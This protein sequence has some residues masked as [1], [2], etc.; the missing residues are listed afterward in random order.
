MDIK[1]QLATL[2]R[3]AIREKIPEASDIEIS[4]ERPRDPSHGDLATNV[5]M[6]I[7]RK[8][9]RKPRDVAELLRGIADP[10]IESLEIAGPG[11]INIR[12]KAGAKTDVIPQVLAAGAAYGRNRADQPE[13]IQVEF[14]S[15]NPTGP[16]HVGHGRQ[17][18]LGDAICNLYDTQGWDVHREFYYNDAGAQIATLANSVQLRARGIKP[19]DA[20]WPE[21][22]YNGDYIQDIADAFLAKETVK[23]D[24]REF[25]ASGHVDDL[26]SIRMFAVAYLRHEQDLDLKAFQV[27]FDHY[28]LESSLYTTGK[29]EE[30]VQ[31]L[32]ASGKTYEQDGALWL[33]T[34]E[35]GDDKDRVMRKSDGT[36]TYFVPDVAYHLT[37][38]ERG[39]TKAVNIQGTDHHGTI[40]RV[41]GG[42]QA[43]GAG[44]PAGYPDYV[45]H[46]MVR[47]LRGGEE[48]KISKRAGS[49]VTLRD[50]I[51]WTSKDAVRFFLL[52]RKPDTEYVFDIDLALAQNNDNPV[53]YVQYA[54]ARICSVL[55]AWG[56]DASTL[57]GA[58]LAALEHP[59]AL[60]LM[61]QL[62][63]YPE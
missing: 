56:G 28:F 31:R 57:A 51:E 10:Q 62:A 47:V 29:V 3:D 63:R 22:A 41:R 26:D 36:Y 48:V 13:K 58:D 7:A 44:I 24:D 19:G 20:A 37:K 18:A 39:F 17:A 16:L 53:F 34:T 9:K 6:Q 12:L 32:I 52:S 1:D 21:A 43:L 60:N 23:A 46:T 42:L 55:A 27:R 35:F 14:V 45:L 33:R 2:F 38:W 59:A 30:T 54:H 50:L 4:F 49:Y 8:L 40:A 61:L 25:T 5:A 15:A 11:F